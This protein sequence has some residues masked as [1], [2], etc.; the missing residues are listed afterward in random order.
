MK[1]R[2]EFDTDNAAFEDNLSWE[3]RQVLEQA[4]R[5]VVCFVTS[6]CG[7]KCSLRDSN[8]NTVGVVEVTPTSQA[9]EFFCNCVRCQRA[10][11]LEAR[12]KK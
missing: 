2:I 8:G 5:E 9:A 3:I 6:D 12:G 11:D 4:D 7:G 1:I 10:R